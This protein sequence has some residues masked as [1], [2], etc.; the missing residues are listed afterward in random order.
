MNRANLGDLIG[1][2]SRKPTMAKKMP[3]LGFLEPRTGRK[4]KKGHR[5]ASKVYHK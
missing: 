3:S 2:V 1:G 5:K 4:V